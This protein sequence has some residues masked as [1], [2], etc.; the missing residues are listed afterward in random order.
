MSMSI[1]ITT[2]A[3]SQYALV[4]G[5]IAYLLFPRLSIFSLRAES[6][7]SVSVVVV[8]SSASVISAASYFWKSTQL[9]DRWQKEV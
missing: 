9:I 4:I 3:Q 5:I 2:G 7:V 8:S 6:F 1:I